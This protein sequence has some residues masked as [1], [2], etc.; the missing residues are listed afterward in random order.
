MQIYH[1]CKTIFTWN[2]FKTFKIFFT[3]H[4]LSDSTRKNDLKF[5]H[6]YVSFTMKLLFSHTI[7]GK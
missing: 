4:L 5:C 6:F 3:S 7:N 2:K 1:Q